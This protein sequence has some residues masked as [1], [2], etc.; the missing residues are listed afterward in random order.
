MKGELS[1]VA[2]ISTGNDKHIFLMQFITKNR[3]I[4]ENYVS[5]WLSFGTF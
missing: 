4:S 1:S 2:S 3:E 5:S